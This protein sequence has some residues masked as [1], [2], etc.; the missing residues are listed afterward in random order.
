MVDVNNKMAMSNNQIHQA[1]TM[2]ANGEADTIVASAA[3]PAA[4]VEM[5][6]DADEAAVRQPPGVGAR[7]ERDRLRLTGTTGAAGA[8]S[9]CRG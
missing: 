5:R 4:L 1:A 3:R 8:A 9:G 7:A 6:H 2:L